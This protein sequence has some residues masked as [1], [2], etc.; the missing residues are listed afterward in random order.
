M[1]KKKSSGEERIKNK[2]KNKEKREKI[3]LKII[4]FTDFY[5]DS[6]LKQ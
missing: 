3:Q 2:K 5:E 6:E 1:V 4:I